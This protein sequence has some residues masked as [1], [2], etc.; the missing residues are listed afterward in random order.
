MATYSDRVGQVREQV[1]GRV[2]RAWNALPNYRDRNVDLF[3]D[4]VVPLVQAGQ[5]QVANLTAAY[6]KA[7]TVD[8]DLILGARG[9]APAMVYRRPAIELYTALSKGT[10]YT[11]AVAQG[12][13]RLADLALTD[14]QMA[15]VRQADVSLKA[16]NVTS[17]RRVLSG[18]EN[19]AL[20]VIA[21][22]QRYR[23]GNLSPIH[24]GCDCEVDELP[25]GWNPDQIVVDQDLLDDT[26]AEIAAQ[27]DHASVTREARDLG[28]G[29]TD[30]RGRP[31]SDYT[32]LIVTR[33]HGEY[34]PTLAWRSQRFTSAEDIAALAN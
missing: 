26:Y 25:V 3:V 34:G 1:R 13:H 23:V 9:V 14:M 32:D 30:A 8:R 2:L 15:K 6:F 18:R 17:Y 33:E 21:S 16:K 4:R 5:M 31:V 29:K 10:P 24:P 19:C 28:L 22:T 12:G 20:C 27:L 7:G 11:R